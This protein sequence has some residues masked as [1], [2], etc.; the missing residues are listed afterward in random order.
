MK[1]VI[2]GI[3]ILAGLFLIQIPSG[4]QDKVKEAGIENQLI[5][6]VEKYNEKDL[7]GAET[8]LKSILAEAPENDAAW[9]WSALV[10][11]GRNN[12]ADAET[13]LKKASELD[14][15][16]FWYRYRLARL[17]RATSRAELTVNMYEKLLEDFPKKS[18]LYFD[19]VDLYAAQG[20]TA[21]A[22]E[23]LKEI[24]TVFGMTESIAVFRFNL[25][26]KEG[27]LKEAI[28]SLEEYN[29]EYS[30][31]YVLTTL[32]DY[33]MSMYNDSTALAYYNEA[34]DIA[35]DYV[36]AILGKAETL[37]MT[38][39]YEDYFVELDKF[40]SVEDNPAAGKSDYLMAIVQRT[41]PKFL[42][43]FRNSMDQII[44]KV[45]AMHPVDS[46][47]LRLAGI[48]YWSTDRKDKSKDYF[49]LNAEN[50]PE[51]LTASVDF[52][53]FLM[54]AEQWEDLSREGRKA[55]DR[56]PQETAFLEMASVG[57]FNREDYDSVLQLCDKVLETAPQDSS[58]T[59]R[60]W[61]T[62]GD[63]WHRKGDAKKA[64][65]AYDKALK[66]NPNYIYVLNN[67]A[68]YLS[69][70]GRNLK[71]AYEMS[72]KT[73]E[74]EPDNSTYLDTFGWILYLQ[75]KAL[76][77]KPFFKHAML[78]GGKDSAVILDHYAEVLYELKEYDLAFV[79][80]DL[81]LQKK[82]EDLPD[83]QKK[84]EARKKAAGR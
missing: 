39:K 48:Y 42:N 51:S 3:I 63:I 13:F 1:N 43:S 2:Y 4:A 21:K 61:S 57:D 76:E 73:I 19:L 68:Y 71:K 46:S 40:I 77:A 27:K 18:E 80:W 28:A 16:N 22:L 78:Y 44:E 47:V 11:L 34:L 50:N 23:T 33:Q 10:S 84:V 35:P 64:Y 37:R 62:I 58:K 49:R 53:E 74:A 29:G 30:S 7:D 65:K 70:E 31:P 69:M 66:I 25:L 24:E 54:Y 9:Y 41:D 82:D 20:E 67:Y 83:L 17:Y 12:A 26:Q 15:D 5:S 72:K 81:A 59:L 45:Y 6:A 55:F 8:L 32:A 79:Y 38:R 14:P 56:F 75:G 52:V 60:A 36:P